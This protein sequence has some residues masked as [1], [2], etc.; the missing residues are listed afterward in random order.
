M[1]RRIE[2]LLNGI[3]EYETPKMEIS[4]EQIKALV[5]KGE[6]VRGSFQ[7]EN[8]SQKK[9][10]GFLYAKSQRAGFEP[11]AF[12]AISE[13]IAYEIDTSGLKEGE[14]LEGEFTICSNIGEYRIPYQVEI[15]K[16]K[17]QAY[18]EE[19]HT[20][21]EFAM[22]AQKDFQKAYMLFVGEGFR[23]FLKE[24]APEFLL[25]YDGLKRQSVNYETLE[26]FLKAAGLKEPVH[27]SVDKKEAFYG[28][29]TQTI[30]EEIVLTKDTWGFVRLL[31]SSD[32]PFLKVERPIVTTDE[33][34]GSTY[35][36]MYLIDREALHGGKNFGR[37]TIE[38]A[39]ETLQVE[40][41]VHGGVSRKKNQ[42][43]P[44]QHRAVFSMYQ[45][46]MD[47]RLGRIVQEEWIT[48]SKEA[49]EEFVKAGGENAMVELFRIQ[50]LFMEGRD[51]E[52][53][54][55]LDRM[56][57]HKEKL[58]E[59]KVRAYF[60]YLT[61]FYNKDRRYIDY[62]ED[63]LNSLLLQ[64]PEQWE[65]Q[66]C[67]LYIR[68]AYLK[69][70][71]Q[72]LEAIRQQ[73]IYGCRSRIM[74]LE[75]A[76][77]LR[78]SPLL[79]KKLE[80]FEIQVLAFIV[81]EGMMDKELA[82][83]MTELSNR[84]REYSD[85]LYW[86]LKNTY[87]VYPQKSL[88]RALAGLLIKGQKKGE[89]AFHWYELG[90]E[91]DVRMT[92]LYEYYIESM[93]KPVEKPLPQIIRMYF[94]YNNTLHYE[95]KAYVYANVIR[96]RESDPHTY[97]S[98]RPAMEKF[99]V[100]QL[101][102]GHLNDDLAFV[103]QT[104]VSPGILNRR[105]AENLSAMLFTY[106]VT[107]RNEKAD[108][109]IVRHGQ[110]RE[111]QKV[112]LVKGKAYV[113]IY[114][115]EHQIFLEDVAGNRYV[116]TIPYE[117]RP[118]L[119]KEEFFDYVKETAPASKGLVLNTVSKALREEGITAHN[120]P[121]FCCLLEL[122]EVREEYREQIRAKILDYY[123]RNQKDASLYDYLHSIDLEEF[124]E[125][126]KYKLVQLLISEG[127]YQDAFGI[128]SRFGPENINLIALVHL[129]HRMVVHLEYEEEE[130]LLSLCQYCFEHGKYDETVLT[131]LLA[132]YDG[133][134]E[135]MKE[136]WRA[137]KKFE[138][139]TF[140]MEEKILIMVLFMRSGAKD[141]EEIFDS[142]RK[143]LGRK[144][145]LKA[146]VIYRAYDYLVKQEPVKEPVFLY[147]QRGYEKGKE[148]EDVCLL[149]LLCYYSKQGELTKRQKE[150]VY[151]LLEEYTNKGIRLAFFKEFSGEYQRTFQLYD[152]TFVEYRA[153]PKALVTIRYQMKR[154]LAEP[155][156][157]VFEGIFVKEFTLF[158]GES[159]TYSIVEEY[160]GHQT[161][162][163]EKTL[164]YQDGDSCVNSRYGLLNQ[165]SKAV[166]ERDLLEAEV[167]V[168][169]Y[170]ER[171]ALAER[172]FTL[173]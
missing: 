34:I 110:I 93:E 16:P 40:V 99:V 161:E 172:I 121:V 107:C 2:Q 118:V 167:T 63:H 139:D 156:T 52:A 30:Q 29:I 12:S 3:F 168:L 17:V 90:V 79:L 56:E 88:V 49:V 145:L 101:L 59:P 132:H 105:L 62:V 148:Q 19:L 158:Y 117:V 18:D 159:L 135:S 122:P 114:T 151:S 66:W 53:C 143:D 71:G 86:I 169:E 48:K 136:I 96:N 75:A 142:Y 6:N 140:Q 15:R 68:E 24:E 171:Q 13:R 78:S 157:Q 137:G 152:K 42:N 133:A 25:L 33:F 43:L 8:P 130:M 163:E 58:E 74:Y 65:I 39:G 85:K 4:T 7:I 166:S 149:A 44:V 127:M 109:V 155:M 120:I 67:L 45:S 10:K 21:Q 32:A 20:I 57:Q 47:Y 141:T 162:T 83:Q 46:Y 147:I 170:R 37:I 94:S 144:L 92:G 115:Q 87:P 164:S 173:G 131:Y 50:L 111:E 80:E 51:E 70:P 123:Y 81:R 61:T 128:V 9:M 134:V 31:V 1:K 112:A 138:L 73:Y 108:Y 11:T 27:I 60:L 69:H 22:L 150:N 129:C 124:V 23:S 106:E 104:F 35:R 5:K 76:M 55:Q 77:V 14:K 119:V 97:Q 26:E 95:R 125:T 84:C 41:T 103:Y 165:L 89:E 100:D 64:N 72:K 126:D 36:L 28:G 146:Y 116:R 113:Q 153:N 102:A 82:M 160:N 91:Q 98:Y 54:I 38:G 154:A